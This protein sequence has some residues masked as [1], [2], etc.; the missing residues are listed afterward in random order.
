MSVR[1]LGCL[2]MAMYHSFSIRGTPRPPRRARGGGGEIASSTGNSS[3]VLSV[4]IS[5]DNRLGLSGSADKTI[6][7]WDIGARAAVSMVQENGEVWFV[8]W[9]SKGAARS[10]VE[11]RMMWLGAGEV[12]VLRLV[13]F[14]V[15]TS[16]VL[17]R[18][19]ASF[20]V[21]LFDLIFP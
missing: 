4:N 7:V 19:N 9:R 17:N 21:L 12:L 5:P 8:S 16:A 13:R 3:W 18:Q 6:K 15:L 10:S 20:C 14:E 11:A 1:D 2:R